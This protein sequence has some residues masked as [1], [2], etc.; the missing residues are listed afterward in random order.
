MNLL[1]FVIKLNYKVNPIGKLIL[2]ICNWKI[3]YYII[4]S[5]IPYNNT[6]IKYYRNF[7]MYIFN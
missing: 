7:N 6:Q 5:I 3:M 2:N 4:Y 1:Y